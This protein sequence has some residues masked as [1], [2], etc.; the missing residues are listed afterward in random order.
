[1]SFLTKFG[2]EFMLRD[3]K[4]LDDIRDFCAKKSGL[5]SSNKNLMCKKSLEVSG[6]KVPNGTD[7]CIVFKDLLKLAS[8]IERPSKKNILIVDQALINAVDMY[9]IESTREFFIKNGYNVKSRLSTVSNRIINTQ[10]LN[11]GTN[12]A[13]TIIEPRK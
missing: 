1:M 12:F 4:T 11:P 13:Q 2:L 5:C 3:K 10:T 9:G 6:Y 7:S 8:G